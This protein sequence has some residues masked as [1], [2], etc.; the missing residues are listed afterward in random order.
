MNKD[1]KYIVRNW[2]HFVEET[3]AD[4]LA[5]DSIDILA[6]HEYEQNGP[7]ALAA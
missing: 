6:C 1:R 3:R 7:S 5:S 4:H 2:E